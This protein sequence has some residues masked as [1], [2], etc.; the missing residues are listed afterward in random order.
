MPKQGI[1]NVFG[2]LI[3]RASTVLDIVSSTV[4]VPLKHASTVI[5]AEG[6]GTVMDGTTGKVTVGPGRYLVQYRARFSGTGTFRAA[7]GV[8]TSES[9][10]IATAKTDGVDELATSGVL[11]GHAIVN[12]PNK[13]YLQLL[14]SNE[15]ATGDITITKCDFTIVDLESR[16]PRAA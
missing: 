6:N 16:E 3:V 2:G 8:A 5:A 1:K 15:G 11:Q 10:A 9:A 7:I 14:F 4:A 12:V 13:T